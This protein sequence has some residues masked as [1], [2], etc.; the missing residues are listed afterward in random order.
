M[1]FCFVLVSV[2]YLTPTISQTRST[3]VAA[4]QLR[5]EQGIE[6]APV[7]FFGRES[8]G[9]SMSLPSDQV[10]YFSMEDLASVCQFLESNPT[11]VLVSSKTEMELLRREMTWAVV[12]DKVESSRHL[13]LCRPNPTLVAEQIDDTDV[14]L[15]R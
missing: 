6:N 8:Y 15:F 11:S 3:H 2:N 10:R 4:S 14:R 9:A 12:F 13:F 7:V 5:F 1:A